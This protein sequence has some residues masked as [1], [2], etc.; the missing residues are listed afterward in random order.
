M[1]RSSAA[2]NA[3]LPPLISAAVAPGGDAVAGLAENAGAIGVLSGPVRTN[4]RRGRFAFLFICL[5]V[6]VFGFRAIAR[7]FKHKIEIR[8]FVRWA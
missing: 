7:P 2:A 4:S 5:P 3:F 1:S 6:L 8:R